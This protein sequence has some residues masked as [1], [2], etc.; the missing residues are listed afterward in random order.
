MELAFRNDLKGTIMQ[1]GNNRGTNSVTK[2]VARGA[3]PGRAPRGARLQRPRAPRPLPIMPSRLSE[4][5]VPDGVWP[6]GRREQRLTAG[7]APG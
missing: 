2:R 4:L 3:D 7:E 5:R 6:L 1:H